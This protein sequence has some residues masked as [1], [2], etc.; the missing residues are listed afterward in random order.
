[1]AVIFPDIEKTLVSYFTSAFAAIGSELTSGI[2]VG[3]KKAQPDDAQPVKEV[4]LIVAYNNEENYVI[5]NATLTIEVYAS[6]YA[7]ANT[8]SLLVESL[9][10]SA[11]GEEIKQVTV[12]LG[13]VRI[14][15]E[16]PYEKRYLDVSLVIK[17]TDL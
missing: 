5:K 7:T 3:T 17:G 14:G 11:V 12:T 10:R 15:E 1:M 2:R 8:L 9:I 6:D 4:V 16:G 13:P